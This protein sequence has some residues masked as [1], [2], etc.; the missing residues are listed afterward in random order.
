MRDHWWWRPG[1]HAGRRFY[2]WHVTFDEETVGQG[3]AALHRL[4]RAYQAHLA[5]PGL[6]LVPC[7]WLHLT[8][9]GVG[10]V[11]EVSDQDIARI[12]EAARSRCARLPPVTVTIGPAR[13]RPEAVGLYVAPAEPVRQV[14]SAI[15]AAI[16]E[17]WG[18]DHVPENEDEF[19]PHVSLAYSNADGPAEPLAAVLATLPPASATVTIRAA[20]LIV[21]RRDEHVYRWATRA[22]VPLGAVPAATERSSEGR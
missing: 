19:T 10:F 16:G 13:L 21:L 6:D 18:A 9:Q 1:W 14:R 22:T 11:D 12:A 3:R 17:V 20:Q 8:M 15:R 7:A 4:A 2:T 5:L